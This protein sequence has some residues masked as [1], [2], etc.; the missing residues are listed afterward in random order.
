MF[1][2]IKRLQGKWRVRQTRKTMKL[3]LAQIHA[4]ER[5]R[6]RVLF[7][8]RRDRALLAIAGDD[9]ALRAIVSEQGKHDVAS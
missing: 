9:Q 8:E 5:A 3:M 4:A 1:D 7:T 2:Y 6:Q